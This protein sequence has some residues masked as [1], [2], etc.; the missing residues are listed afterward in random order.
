MQGRQVSLFRLAMQRPS[1]PLAWGRAYQVAATNNMRVPPV[2]PPLGPLQD[3]Y[4]IIE[5]GGH[6]I[7]TAT[8]RD[9]G[10]HPTWNE[11]YTLVVHPGTG[12]A[13]AGSAQGGKRE[14]GEAVGC[15]A[16]QLC[17][18]IRALPEL[19]HPKLTLAM[20]V[21]AQYLASPSARL[22]C[23][24]K[25]ATAAVTASHDG[26]V[27]VYPLLGLDAVQKLCT[28]VIWR[29]QVTQLSST[30]T[31]TVVSRATR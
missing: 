20:A 15:C 10:D 8:C 23:A 9:G 14:A 21:M 16:A 4:C 12:T 29:P 27:P 7:R 30:P 26:G 19:Q 5:V 11:H 31:M 17:M 22:H 6:R 28:L 25:H 13:H 24:L 1:L 18:G 3:P 2:P